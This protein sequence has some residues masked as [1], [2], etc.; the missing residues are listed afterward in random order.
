VRIYTYDNRSC[1]RSCRCRRIGIREVRVAVGHKTP[2]ETRLRLSYCMKEQASIILSA[3]CASTS[4]LS[5][6][7][8]PQD[9]YISPARYIVHLLSH[10]LRDRERLLLLQSR[11]QPCTTATCS[12]T[13]ATILARLPAVYCLQICIPDMDVTGRMG[14]ICTMIMTNMMV[15]RGMIE[16]TRRGVC[17][18]RHSRPKS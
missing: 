17:M 11:T 18:S 1:R 2:A 7:P 14:M 6:S 3:A 13:Q 4:A 5:F 16:H 9:N 10:H 12:L 8:P 15:T